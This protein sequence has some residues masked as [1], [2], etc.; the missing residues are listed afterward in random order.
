LFVNVIVGILEM[1][2]IVPVSNSFIW[3]SKICTFLL[4]AYFLLFLY[5][6]RH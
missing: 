6:S 5:F 4:I 2:L 1:D 3:V